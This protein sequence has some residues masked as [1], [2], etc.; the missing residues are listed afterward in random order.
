MFQGEFRELKKHFPGESVRVCIS[1]CKLL[2]N[3]LFA[4]DTSICYSA[5]N[6]AD[7]TN[8]VN[9]LGILD[10][11][12]RVS[13]LSLITIKTNVMKFTNKILPR[14]CVNIVLKGQH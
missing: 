11:W 7:V 8:A 13:E 4:D 10:L 5:S 2:H 1:H 6:T 14:T 12:F 9:E 3:V